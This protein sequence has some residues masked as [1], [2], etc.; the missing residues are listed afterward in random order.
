MACKYCP[1]AFTDES[2]QAQNYGCLPSPHEIIEL[3]RKTGQNWGCHSNDQKICEG[4]VSHVKR[5]NA[6]PWCDDL[7]DIDTS[8][9]GIISFNTWEEKGSTIAIEEAQMNIKS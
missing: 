3:K 9:G 4:Y 1:F 2:E 5:Q 8:T 6:S 7:N